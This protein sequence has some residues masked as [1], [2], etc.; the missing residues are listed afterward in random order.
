[1]T[2]PAL[3]I[4]RQSARFLFRERTIALLSALFFALVL[5]SAYLGWSATTTVNAIYLKVAA[6][7]QSTGK[8][9]PPNPVHDISPLS[10]LRNMSTYVM[11]IGSLAAINVGH[12]LVALDRRS[13]IISLIGVRPISPATY[14][15]GKIGALILVLSVL[16]G[17]AMVVSVL[18]FLALPE[19]RLHSDGWIKLVGFFGLSALYMVLF[20][21]IG[22]AVTANVRTQSVGLL[23]PVTLWLT[24]T[25]I[26]PTLTANIHPTASLNPVVAM[27]PP[28]DAAFF[29][30]TGWTLGPVSLS[31]AYTWVS[32]GLLDFRPEG[33][34][35]RSAISPMLS[36]I[37]ATVIAIWFAVRG[38]TGLDRSHGDFDA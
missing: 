5:L 21:L 31:Q 12:Q 26:L 36:L 17:F 33:A 1:M 38:L 7:L 8:P 10:L 32:A 15:K 13:G 28:P 24:L 22:I 11:L 2:Y 25:F 34:A 9:V 29:T 20:G 14:A 3:I 37:L 35:M 4:A 23:V 16:M 30:F 18:S 6:F 19:F 27:A